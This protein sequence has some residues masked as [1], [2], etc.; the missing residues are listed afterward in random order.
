MNSMFNNCTSLIFLN[1]NSFEIN[2]ETKIESAFN[3]LSPNIK[4]CIND[5]ITINYLLESYNYSSD[6]SNLCFLSNVKLDLNNSK[7]ICP[8]NTYATIN[9]G[10]VCAIRCIGDTTITNV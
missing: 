9:L 5:S 1:L 7:C 4:F 2:N 3:S 8:D 6:C 10:C